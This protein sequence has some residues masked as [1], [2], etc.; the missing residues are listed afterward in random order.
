VVATLA[1]AALVVVALWAGGGGSDGSDSGAA[2]G[3]DRHER[4]SA[5]TTS[6]SEAPPTTAGRPSSPPAAEGSPAAGESEAP[7]TAVLADGRHP[8]FFTGFDVAGST[9]EFDL[10]QYLTGDEAHAYAEAHEDEYGDDYYDQYVVNEN[11]RLR[12]LPVAGDVEI[13]VL[14][15]A[16]STNSPHA[17]TFRELPGYV[18]PDQG[19][20][21]P[22]LG[23]NVFWL[24]VRDGS[25]V[26]IDEQYS[27]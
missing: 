6:P 7:T 9:V 13:T 8:V 12:T 15:T 14:Q 1:A 23:A 10:V 11:P 24:T 27:A 4:A 19:F 16:E 17:I 25:V 18:G 21:T 2:G 5:P 3:G 20:A 22:H 26:A